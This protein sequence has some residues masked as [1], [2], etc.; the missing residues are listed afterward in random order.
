MNLDLDLLFEYMKCNLFVCT[1]HLGGRAKTGCLEIRI[2]CPSGATSLLFQWSSTI[3][4]QLSVLV[5]FKADIIF[6]SSNVHVICFSHSCNISHLALNSLQFL[7]QVNH[8]F[9]FL[10]LI[11]ST[12]FR[13]AQNKSAPVQSLIPTYHEV[14]STQLNLIKDYHSLAAL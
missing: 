4:I 6:I 12:C 2:L 11:F 7:H 14:Y 10:I 8:D 13:F 9:Y 1:H 3:R 5:Q